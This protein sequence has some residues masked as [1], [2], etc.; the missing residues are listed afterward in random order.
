MV[1]TKRNSG[2]LF[3]LLFVIDV[4]LSIAYG[5]REPFGQ[6]RAERATHEYVQNRTP[7][8]KV[9]MEEDWEHVFAP[10]RR[11]NRTIVAVFSADSCL[12]VI[13]AYRLAR[14]KS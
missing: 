4:V 11:R 13:V 3:I 10:Q 14:M 7:Q 9:A 12:L 2:V 5:Y 1:M 8:N 6:G